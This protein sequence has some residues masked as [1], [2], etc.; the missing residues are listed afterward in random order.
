MKTPFKK[1]WKM[2]TMTYQIN[3]R[4]SRLFLLL[5]AGVLMA[6]VTGACTLS[7]LD[8][9][10]GFSPTPTTE[11]PYTL[12][13]SPTPYPQAEVTFRVTLP[14]ASP[15]GEAIFL[16]IL[17]EVTGLALNAEP[18]RME[19]EDSTH[20]R[21][22][23]RINAG[24]IVKYRYSREGALGVFE[25][26]TNG[27][28][29]RYRMAYVEGPIFIEDLITRWSD[30]LYTEPTGRIEGEITDAASGRPLPD[31]LVTAGGL[32]TV[33]STDGTY[34]LEGLPAGQHN[35]VAYAFDGSYS[36]FQQGAIVGENATTPAPMN[37]TKVPLIDVTF[38][39]I[40]PQDTTPGVPIRIAGNL[41]QL[42]N[43]FSDLEGG[44][45]TLTSQMPIL[46]PLAD[47]RQTITL[48]LPAGADIRYK[49]SLGD[50][51]WN[52]EH[53]NDGA[54]RV[55]QL[56][57][58][59]SSHAVEDV[60]STWRAG[61][62]API[63]F[64]VTVPDDTPASDVI[65]I[66][67]NPYG[68][69]ESIPM[70]SLGGNRW[71]YLLSG[72]LETLGTIG[73]R[74]C[75][76]NQCGIAD[77]SMTPGLQSGGRPVSTSLLPQNLRNTVNSWEWFTPLTNPVTVPGFEIPNRGGQFI[78]GV[79]ISGRYHP[80]W[81]PYFSNAMMTLQGI[82]ANN[83]V[84]TPSWTFTRSSPP[85]LDP[86]PGQDPL[87]ADNITMIT[88]AQENDLTVILRPVPRFSL[89]ADEWW[90]QGSRDAAWWDA[91]FEQYRKFILNFAD[92]G[93]SEN[94]PILV[95]GGDWVR[96]ALPEGTLA[97][98]SAS[99]VPADA[100]ARWRSLL[101]EVNTRYDGEIV[102]A[103]SYNAELETPPAFLDEVD[104][105]M[106]LW[107][108]PLAANTSVSG[109]E[110]VA[111]AARRLDTE[112]LPALAP[113]ELPVILNIAY[114]SASGGITGCL[115]DPEGGCLTI[116]EMSKPN[117]EVPQLELDLTEQVEA[118]NALLTVVADRGW[119]EGFIAR[120]F[121]PAVALRDKSTG[122]YG[123]PAAD[124]LSYWYPRLLG[125]PIP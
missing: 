31:I 5:V 41:R 43:T 75:R 76:N 79:E 53:E 112:V 95:L 42:G 88:Q 64:D 30:T 83:V 3:Q 18:L 2:I 62:S 82:S 51:F 118:Y 17:D 73:Y 50:G 7:L 94:A 104:Q 107:Q 115:P 109:A 123:K 34:L 113:Y 46:T 111:E 35:L 37:L 102:W 116:F 16:S 52:A 48:S 59:A 44:I 85:V 68:W 74:Y 10:A 84:L 81:S 89:K 77:D 13:P 121:Y 114:P 99:G 33:T 117:P 26:S 45:S 22:T 60:V 38:T 19:V 65:S 80:S 36:P 93:T 39:V 125:K 1:S 100:E 119:I 32:Q 49:Y 27:L 110:L 56:I 96:P 66:Q 103:L 97:D 9:P 28:P 63:W 29:V 67:F 58:P 14:E 70:W 106:L 105:V 87:L 47:G 101:A 20:Y 124:A 24:S 90:A 92:L 4:K 61:N 25:H 54:F 120:D 55:R 21:I 8:I 69:T 15:S 71:V 122:I 57:V 11:L 78:A 108:A 98:G 12:P 6:L 23:T 86:V 72:P 91:W 40:L